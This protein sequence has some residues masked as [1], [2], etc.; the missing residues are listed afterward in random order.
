MAGKVAVMGLLERHGE[1]GKARCASTSW[2]TASSSTCSAPSASNVE[3]GAT[4]YTD[5]LL[6]Y[7]GLADA[8]TSTTSST[9]SSS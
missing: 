7:H 1:K 8:T 9:T 5:A 2:T 6:S 4:V 3:P